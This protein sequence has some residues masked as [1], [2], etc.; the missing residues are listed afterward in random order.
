MN[1][2]S[3]TKQIY[4]LVG[5]PVEGPNEQLFDERSMT[6][7][8][9]QNILWRT[10]EFSVRGNQQQELLSIQLFTPVKIVA[11]N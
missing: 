1:N 2:G 11:G 10:N 7:A 4:Q 3:T 8:L 6:K 5:E 9:Q